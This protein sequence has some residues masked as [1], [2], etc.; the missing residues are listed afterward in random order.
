MKNILP[1]SILI[2]VAVFAFMLWNPGNFYIP[3]YG[4]ALNLQTLALLIAIPLAIGLIVGFVLGWSRGRGSV[5][6]K[7]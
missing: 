6:V 7:A 3:F 5:R 1:I 2:V 4:N